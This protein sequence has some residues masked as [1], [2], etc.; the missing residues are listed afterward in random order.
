MEKPIPTR[1]GDGSLTRMT[2]SQLRAELEEGTRAAAA[3]AKVPPLTE[4]ELEHLLEIWASPAKFT[5]V[6]IGDEVV[7]TYDGSGSKTVATR[8][9]DLQIYEQMFGA[10]SVELGHVDY[11]F[12]AIRT[13]LPF[14]AQN[15]KDAQAVL[16]VPVM[17]GA[18][19]NLG[20]YSKPD[21]PA[22]NWSELLPLARV[23]EARAAQEEAVEHAVNDMVQA[24]EA[25]WAAGADGI[26]FDTAG[27]AGDGDFLATLLAVE[28]IRRAH[29]DMGIQVGMAGE[30]VLGM[31]GRLEYDGVRLAGLWPREQ[32]RLVRRAGATIF[33]PAVTVNTGKSGAWNVARALTLVRPCMADAE[34]PVHMNI[35][36]GVGGVPMTS[37]LPLDAVARA[38]RATVDILR[39]DGL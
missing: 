10:D 31:H 26:D 20:L 22:P 2:R 39:L 38:S 5:A 27:A 7:L 4:P 29:P 36:M 3:R 30:F 33:G 8:T 6:D 9:Q 15:M 35:G 37:Y 23:D 24:A 17:Y 21:G 32:L 11:S 12:K 19:P 28:K 25:M 1:L 13:I 18:M 34:I 16:T 14:E